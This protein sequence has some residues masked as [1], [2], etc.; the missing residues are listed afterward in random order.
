M[1]EQPPRPP[2]L[3]NLSQEIAVPSIVH[4][5]GQARIVGVEYGCSYSRKNSQ[6]WVY[7]LAFEEGGS[8]W[9]AREEELVKWQGG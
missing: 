7:Y 1:I 5:S 4:P 2:R 6:G 8:A 9:E 3:F